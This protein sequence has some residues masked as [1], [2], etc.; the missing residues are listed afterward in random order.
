AGL[1]AQAVAGMREGWSG[2][3]GG[4]VAGAWFAACPLVWD[5]G[6]HRGGLNLALIAAAGMAA[7][8]VA[9]GGVERGGEG[10]GARA[11]L[12]AAAGAVVLV[13]VDGRAWAA[14][15]IV[16]ALLAR[17]GGRRT[18]I[19]PA[20]IGVAGAVIDAMMIA[21]R[22]LAWSAPAAVSRAAWSSEV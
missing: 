20:M 17:R 3:I 21:G 19:A 2:A 1:I 12:V 11:R 10:G 13:A 18:A 8:V 14:A 4:A 6:A 9:A 5:A 7:A 15:V 22:R 16:A